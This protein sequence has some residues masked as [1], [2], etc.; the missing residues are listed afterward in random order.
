MSSLKNF[1]PV[2]GRSIKTS[3]GMEWPR[4][5]AWQDI[6]QGLIATLHEKQLTSENQN[7][8]E[9][10]KAGSLTMRNKQQRRNISFGYHYLLFKSS[11]GLWGMPRTGFLSA[12]SE[13]FVFI[14]TL[15]NQG[16]FMSVAA[17]PLRGSSAL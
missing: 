15:F 12:P 17:Q 14:T 5:G 16:S 4:R 11:E 10:R 2:I 1:K 6:C 13:A 3:L 8:Q 9:E 7:T